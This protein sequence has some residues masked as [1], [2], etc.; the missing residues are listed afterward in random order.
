MDYADGKI[1]VVGATGDYEERGFVS[2]AFMEVISLD[3]GM[4]FEKVDTIIDISSYAGT[5]INEGSVSVVCSSR[6]R[7]SSV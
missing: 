1:Y 5:D 3:A 7:S 4:A 6:A 2:A